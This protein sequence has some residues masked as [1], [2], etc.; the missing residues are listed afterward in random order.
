MFY[1]QQYRTV[2][3]DDDARAWASI[4]IFYYKVGIYLTHR[5]ITHPKI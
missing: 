2:E 5:T 3:A 1:E 4:F